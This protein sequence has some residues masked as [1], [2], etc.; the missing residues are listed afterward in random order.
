MRLAFGIQLQFHF[1]EIEASNEVF[2]VSMRYNFSRPKL[3]HYL[4][5]G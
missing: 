4:G 1:H 3:N 5:F 2:F